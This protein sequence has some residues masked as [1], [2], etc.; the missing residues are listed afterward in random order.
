MTESSTQKPITV[1]L[2]C[3][4][5]HI[6]RFIIHENTGTREQP[7][8]DEGHFVSDEKKTQHRLRLWGGQARQPRQLR[9]LERR[10]LFSCRAGRTARA[11]RAA[12]REWAIVHAELKCIRCQ[13]RPV[14][15]GMFGEDGIP[16]GVHV[17]AEVIAE[18]RGFLRYFLR[19]VVRLI[20]LAI[21]LCFGRNGRGLRFADVGRVG[22]SPVAA[23]AGR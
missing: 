22:G 17:R 10:M 8:G 18:G 23:D 13:D 12:V 11:E 14:K 3:E 16:S 2:A 4:C 5:G 21:V 20:F 7:A 19:F 9:L 15:R 1:T 6:E